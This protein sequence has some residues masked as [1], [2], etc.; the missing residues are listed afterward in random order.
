MLI[1]FIFNYYDGICSDLSGLFRSNVQNPRKWPNRPT[2]QSATWNN[3]AH[4]HCQQSSCFTFFFAQVGIASPSYTILSLISISFLP[5]PCLNIDI[6][7]TICASVFVLLVIP[8]L[9][10]RF[11]IQAHTLWVKWLIL[12]T[13]RP[14]HIS[15]REICVSFIFFIGFQKD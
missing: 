6:S 15:A 14:K 1:S 11:R 8:T 7:S 10:P 4:T 2:N 9:F 5:E 12:P 13:C 3:L